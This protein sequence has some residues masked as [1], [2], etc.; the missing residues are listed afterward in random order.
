MQ[1]GDQPT[2]MI[3]PQIGPGRY[4]LVFPAP[5]DTTLVFLRMNDTVINCRALAGRYEP[6]F[7]AIGL[8][9]AAL[10]ELA[11][12]TGG[13]LIESRDR[14]PIKFAHARKPL[15]VSSVSAALGAVL[16]AVALIHWRPR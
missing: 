9:R 10:R 15:D 7:E 1:P 4:E 13:R 14:D 6:E 2:R 3:I 12:R 5:K 11:A 16:I 8:N